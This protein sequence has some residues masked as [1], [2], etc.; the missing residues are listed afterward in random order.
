MTTKTRER[1]ERDGMNHN[2]LVTLTSY[3]AEQGSTAQEVAYAVEKPWK[4]VDTLLE[5]VATL[6]V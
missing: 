6:D 2:D 1:V 4:F 5:A 3:M